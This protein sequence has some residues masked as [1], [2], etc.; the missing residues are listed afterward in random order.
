[1]KEFIQYRYVAFIILIIVSF[2]FIFTK[3]MNKGSD[4]PGTIKNFEGRQFAGSAACAQCHKNI[5]EGHLKTAH[6]L[7]TRI[8]NRQYIRG[9][10]E[11]GK[12]TYSY[13]MN[14]RVAMEE[15]DSS[16]YQVEYDDGDQKTAH[17]IDI[18]IGSGTMGQSFLT[19]DNKRLFQL[20]IT[21]FTAA[22]EWSNS[23]GY[24]D[25]IVF[26]RPITSRCLEC[27]ST[28]VKIVPTQKKDPENFDPA[29]IIYGVDCEKCHGPAAEHVAFQSQ[30][31]TI[32]TAQYI[33]NPARLSRQQNLDLCASCHGG[34]LDKTR[35]SFEFTVGDTLSKFFSLDT[36]SPNPTNI[37]VHGNQY[38]LLRSSKCFRQSQTLTCN[39]CHNTHETEKGNTALFSNRCMG[40]HSAGHEKVC[41][42]TSTI[43]PA[44]KSNCIDCHMPLKPSRAIA[45]FLPG[46]TAPTAAMIR[47][48]YVSIYPEQTK[49]VSE[50]LKQK[51]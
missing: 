23:P 34:R 13:G 28:F 49:Q 18:V 1:M 37:D 41:A 24:P 47:S 48:H 50:F 31:P 20:P 44:I 22:H 29:Q 26:D 46:A 14:H 25:R 21:Y 19:W 9:S 36:T 17:R 43:G 6:Y 39:T 32:K 5:Y 3:C 15:R 30:N 2:V 42:M 45:V 11:T 40:C 8:A 12:N 51:H 35:P 10:F 16:F 33:L 4:L 7:T 38:G 27:H